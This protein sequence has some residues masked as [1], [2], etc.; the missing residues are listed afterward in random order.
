MKKSLSSYFF[1]KDYSFWVIQ[2]ICDLSPT[3]EDFIRLQNVKP[4]F[5]HE[6][7]Q[8]FFQSDFPHLQQFVTLNTCYVSIF[9][10]SQ[11]LT[12]FKKFFLTP[13]SFTSVIFSD[14]FFRR[15]LLP[16]QEFIFQTLYCN[17]IINLKT[18]GESLVSNWIPEYSLKWFFFVY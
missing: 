11:H 16:L 2:N 17:A 9:E 10:F 13:T 5:W 15:F 8:G 6:R 3:T 7:K 18:N 1:V 4:L 12:S 14:V